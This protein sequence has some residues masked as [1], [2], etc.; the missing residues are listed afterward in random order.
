MIWQ[1]LELYNHFSSFI[2]SII[3]QIF[4][5]QYCVRVF[6]YMGFDTVFEIDFYG[7]RFIFTR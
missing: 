2:L 4:I 6:M 1:G 5:T 3:R 7:Q